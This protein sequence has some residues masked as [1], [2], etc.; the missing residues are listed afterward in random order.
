MHS[1]LSTFLSAFLTVLDVHY[2][3]KKPRR[4]WQA[5]VLTSVDWFW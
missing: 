3:S 4:L 5:V 2:V 1:L